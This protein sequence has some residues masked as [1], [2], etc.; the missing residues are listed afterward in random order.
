MSINI[1]K[2][3]VVSIF[4][5]GIIFFIWTIYLGYNI[6][7]F[8]DFSKL[9]LGA[10]AF[11]CKEINTLYPK[12]PSI[13]DMPNLHNFAKKINYPIRYGIVTAFANHPI[14][15]IPMYPITFFSYKTA[16]TLFLIFNVF[17][18]FLFIKEIYNESSHKIKLLFLIGITLLYLPTRSNI[19]SAEISFPMFVLLLKMVKYKDWLK[20]VV[21][22]IVLL[23]KPQFA[24]I[25][26]FYFILRKHYKAVIFSVLTYCM[27]TILTSLIFGHSLVVD[28]FRFTNLVSCGVL[29]SPQNQSLIGV[30]NKITSGVFYKDA[31]F[32]ILLK[33][34]NIIASRV[35]V[36]IGIILALYLLYKKRAEERLEIIF[37]SITGIILAPFMWFHYLPITLSLLPY[38][39]CCRLRI[40]D[41][42]LIYFLGI[43]FTFFHPK[44][45]ILPIWITGIQFLLGVIFIELSCILKFIKT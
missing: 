16:I 14:L 1:K 4:L 29:G 15:L 26:I 3:A 30:I 36:I 38:F 5:S 27:G 40:R 13:P 41:Y 28:F 21:L 9:Y 31:P 6:T 7:Y 12:D 37:C 25:L 33:K 43:F 44:F 19:Y 17:C 45:N 35:I 24:Y 32:F 10:K 20:G 18:M 42:R 8:G 23:I 22:G 34:S 2:V 11:F 39:G